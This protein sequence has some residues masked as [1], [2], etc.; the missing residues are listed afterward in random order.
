MLINPLDRQIER[1]LPETA[2][3]SV[4][5][6]GDLAHRIANYAGNVSNYLRANVINDRYQD[7]LSAQTEAQMQLM[8]VSLQSNLSRTEHETKMSIVRNIR[9]A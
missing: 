9:V 4:R 5:Q 6:I 7:L 1:Y 3:G 2:S 8:E